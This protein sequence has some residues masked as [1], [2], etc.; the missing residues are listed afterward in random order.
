MLEAFETFDAH[1][2][3]YMNANEFAHLVCSLGEALSKE[4]AA[5]I[6]AAAKPDADD[7]MN[8]RVLCK[9]MCQME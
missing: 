7:Q 1:G 4:E 6:V 5:A 9:K 8:Y 3:G 2:T